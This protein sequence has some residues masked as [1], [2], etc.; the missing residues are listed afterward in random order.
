MLD[1]V[2]NTPTRHTFGEEATRGVLKEMLFLKFFGIFT[3]K[4]LCW[5]LFK[6]VPD[7][8]ACNF[9]K[10]RLQHRCFLVHIAKFLR[11]PL[12]KNICERLLLHLEVRLSRECTFII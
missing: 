8:Q 5:S 11:T 6:K 7:H 10:K 2:A 12:L 1:R 4:H 9:L 3:G